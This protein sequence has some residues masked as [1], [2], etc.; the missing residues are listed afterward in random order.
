MAAQIP[1]V[2]QFA[3]SDLKIDNVKNKWSEKC[4]HCGE[5]LM[6]TRSSTSGFVT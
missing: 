6:E 4:N 2:V 1:K 3:Y 5:T